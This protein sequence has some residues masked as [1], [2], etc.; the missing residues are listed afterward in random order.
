[1]RF[2]D[3]ATGQLLAAHEI[4][5][6]GD[7]VSSGFA[8]APPANQVT[9][10]WTGAYPLTVVV[11]LFE[12]DTC[13]AKE[14][15]TLD[16]QPATSDAPA[17]RAID[18][19]RLTDLLA[20]QTILELVPL[21]DNLGVVIGL[22]ALG[23]WP[24]TGMGL[25]VEFLEDGNVLASCECWKHDKGFGDFTE[26]PVVLSGAAESLVLVGRIPPHLQARITAKADLALRNLGSKV[27]WQGTFTVPH[28][29]IH[30][31]TPSH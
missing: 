2:V 25:A 24:N 30:P 29:R 4:P 17:I 14:L 20:H 19:Q 9:L 22:P 7:S 12:R 1:L 23:K 31:G 21:G 3:E 27:Y 6:W 5:G 10:P 13:L 8:W 11:E 28:D 26:Y 15:V 18:D 16:V